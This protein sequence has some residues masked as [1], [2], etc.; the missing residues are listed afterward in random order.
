[1]PLPEVSEE[2]P[3]PI[4]ELVFSCCMCQATP[5]EVYATVESTHGFNSGGSGE[6]DI[7]TKMWITSCSH[8]TCSVHLQDGGKRATAIVDNQC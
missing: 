1:M 4:E 5:T 8:I 7:V 3:V 2:G 6:D